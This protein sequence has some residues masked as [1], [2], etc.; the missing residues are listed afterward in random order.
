MQMVSCSLLLISVYSSHMIEKKPPLIFNTRLYQT[1]N[2]FKRKGWSFPLSLSNWIKFDSS[3]VPP[4]IACPCRQF[5]DFDQARTV[6][7]HCLFRCITG[8]FPHISASS[9]KVCF[10]VNGYFVAFRHLM[11]LELRQCLFPVWKPFRNKA[12]FL[13]SGSLK[14]LFCILLHANET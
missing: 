4:C 10:I 11:F 14:I 12:G 1:S 8:H 3:S 6:T 5:N 13:I 7:L 9:G 2:Y